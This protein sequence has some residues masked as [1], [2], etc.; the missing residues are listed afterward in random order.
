M[1]FAPDSSY[2]ATN[3]EDPW[4]NNVPKNSFDIYT[5]TGLGHG[6]WSNSRKVEYDWRYTND[7]TFA[8]NGQ[9]LVLAIDSYPNNGNTP[10]CLIFDTNTWNLVQ[11]VNL[12]GWTNYQLSVALSPDD[13]YLALGDDDDFVLVAKWNDGNS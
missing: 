5:R 1:A 10:N 6:D 2:F 9:W 12:P 11:E 7:M 13:Q 3:A 4:N 8:K